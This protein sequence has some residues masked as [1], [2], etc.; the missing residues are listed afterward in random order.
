MQVALISFQTPK[1]TYLVKNKEDVVERNW[2]DQ[3]QEEP[4]FQIMFRDQFRIKDH[5]LSIVLLHYTCKHK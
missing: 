5:L 2:T 3:V 1:I 4:C